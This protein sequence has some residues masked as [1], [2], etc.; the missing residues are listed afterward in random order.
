LTYITIT[1]HSNEL[2]DL[3]SLLK[4]IKISWL[5]QILTVVLGKHNTVLLYWTI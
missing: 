3:L 5:L 1:S 4:Y 2:N